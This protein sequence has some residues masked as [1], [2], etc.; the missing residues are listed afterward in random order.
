MTNT[1]AIDQN[2]ISKVIEWVEQQGIFKIVVSLAKSF[3]DSPRIF[4]YKVFYPD[5]SMQ[6]LTKVSLNDKIETV[7]SV[8]RLMLDLNAS[9]MTL[10][11]F[12]NM[13]EQLDYKKAKKLILEDTEYDFELYK[14]IKE[15]N[16]W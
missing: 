2:N 9:N 6:N 1:I 8:A 11:D 13:L 7:Q 14:K 15:L 5:E 10:D 12:L 3:D 16:I 4:V